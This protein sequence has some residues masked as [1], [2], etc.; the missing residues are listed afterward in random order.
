MTDKK[1]PK[2]PD[3]KNPMPYIKEVRKRQWLV[4]NEQTDK[5]ETDSSEVILMYFCVHCGNRIGEYK[6]LEGEKW[7]FQPEVEKC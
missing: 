4:W 7:G 6:K 2:C 3:C 1:P 5:Y